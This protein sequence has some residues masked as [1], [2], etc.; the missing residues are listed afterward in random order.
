MPQDLDP[1]TEALATHVVD[2]CF[3][4]HSALGPGFLESVYQRA[5]SVELEAR[6]IPAA[7]EVPIQVRYRDQVVGDGRL[8]LVADGR[9]V[10]ECK[11]VEALHDIH[12]AQLISY[13]KATGCQLGFLVNFKTP[14]LKDGIS[15]IVRTS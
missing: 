2:A 10:V 4:V 3:A 13:L 12:R 7:R 5:L 15:R 6:G 14:R 9:I 8:D 11:T 1:K